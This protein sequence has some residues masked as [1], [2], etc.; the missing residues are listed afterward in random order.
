LPQTRVDDLIGSFAQ[1]QSDITAIEDSVTV[2]GKKKLSVVAV[3][4]RASANT[5]NYAWGV[6]IPLGGGI[7]S[8]IPSQ[9]VLGGYQQQTS[10]TGGNITLHYDVYQW[11]SNELDPKYTTIWQGDTGGVFVPQLDNGI[12]LTANTLSVSRNQAINPFTVNVVLDLSTV[13]TN[14]LSQVGLF[15]WTDGNGY[16]SQGGFV[17]VVEV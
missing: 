3:Q 9:W 6:Y 14:R 13:A 4:Q 17:Q 7:V 2:I 11:F 5:N 16:T 10:T 12:V 8:N 15:V 1:I